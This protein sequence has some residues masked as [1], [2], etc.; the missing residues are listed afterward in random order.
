[1]KIVLASHNKHKIAELQSLM[2]CYLPDIQILSLSD[3]GLDADIVEDGTTFEANAQI[4]AEYA[5]SSGYIGIGDD[6]GLCVE[7]LNGAPGI[8]SARFAGT[9]GDSEA[10]NNKLLEKL[11]N[12]KN[13]KA[14]FVCTIA[15]VFPD[16]SQPF[17]VRGETEGEILYDYCGQG[18]F[19]YDPLFMYPPLNKTFAQLSSDEKNAV[20]HRGRAIESFA[21]EFLK[22]VK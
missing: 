20:S 7:A 3:V 11:K 13:R 9:D 2:S 5:A 22:R 18:G 6:S 10:N 19:G 1:M 21:K 14:K 16:G 15:C 4:K 12:E 8:F 17:T